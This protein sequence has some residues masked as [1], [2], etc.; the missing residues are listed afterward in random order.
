MASTLP[1]AHGAQHLLP[2]ITEETFAVRR[3]APADA[4]FPSLD[5]LLAHQDELKDKVVVITGA[6]Q[7][8]GFAAARLAAKAGAKVVISDKNEGP[9]VK[10]EDDLRKDGDVYAFP[11][12]VTSWPSQVTLFRFAVRQF[13]RVDH[14]IANAGCIDGKPLLDE[15]EED[16]GD[17]EPKEPDLTPYKVNAIGTTYT[18][19]LAFYHLRRNPSPTH[20]SLVL[21]GSI[22]S[23]FGLPTQPL[24]AASKHAVLGLARSLFYEGTASGIFT[25]IVCPCITPTPIF[26]AYEEALKLVKQGKVDDVA[27]AMVAGLTWKKRGLTFVTDPE[28]VVVLPQKPTGS[29]K[30]AEE[31]E[32]QKAEAEQ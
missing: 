29:R 24:Y 20:K 18:A 9:L 5:Q 14:V 17:H 10:S 19:K 1:P 16:E 26:G 7:G 30:S 22:A 25:N 32:K 12:D 21:V 31:K 2:V 23:L 15:A 8:L 13:G 27:A 6:A 3:N 28:G 4:E 11:C